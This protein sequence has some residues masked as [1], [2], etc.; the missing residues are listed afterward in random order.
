MVAMECSHFYQNILREGSGCLTT[1]DHASNLVCL[2]RRNAMNLSGAYVDAPLTSHASR[3]GHFQVFLLILAVVLQM[4]L[5]SHA[6]EPV[7][8]FENH[9]DV[10]AVLHPGS[11]SFDA[12]KGTYTLTGSGENMWLAADAFQFAWKKISGDVE[13]SANMSFAT[14][15]GNEHKKAVLMLRQSLDADSVYA[16]VALHSS[17]LTALQYR[18]AKG[19]ITQEVQSNIS[20]PARLRITRRGNDVYMSLGGVGE[21]PQYS[22]AS[23]RVPLSGEFYVGIGVCSHDKNA[24]EKAAFSNVSLRALGPPA[25]RP[26]LN[27]SL[28]TISVSSTDRKVVYHAEGRS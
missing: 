14:T 5:G 26:V 27:S 22:G 10:G 28:E 7:G 15:T 6:Q 20:A 1:F 19:A 25:A 13:L 21:K 12:A 18:D 4:T 11:A 17:G 3:M 9:T 16:D 8:M 2:K 24:I 23:I